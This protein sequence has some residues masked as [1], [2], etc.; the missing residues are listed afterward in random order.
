MKDPIIFYVVVPVTVIVVQVVVIM[1]LYKVSY[2]LM[3]ACKQETKQELQIET[4]LEARKAI[5]AQEVER[6]ELTKRKL[7]A[8]AEFEELT[9]EE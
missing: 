2:S 6:A 5:V 1:A 8:I 9:N 3:S 4:G 7:L